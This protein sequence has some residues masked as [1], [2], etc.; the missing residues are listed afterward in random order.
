M[1]KLMENGVIR[2]EEDG[3]LTFIAQSDYH[4][5]WRQFKQWEAEG[6]V[7]EP[8]DEIKPAEP[9]APVV[10]DNQTMGSASINNKQ[11][12]NAAFNELVNLIKSI[13]ARLTKLEGQQA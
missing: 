9:V 5:A 12:N 7:P 8:A 10:A 13:D 2:T 1:Y 11:P 4:G 3:S 6:N